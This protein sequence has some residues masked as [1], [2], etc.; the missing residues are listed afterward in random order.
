M[1]GLG[2]DRRS[3]GELVTS[4]DLRWRVLLFSRQSQ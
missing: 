1:V 2:F 3:C 4:A